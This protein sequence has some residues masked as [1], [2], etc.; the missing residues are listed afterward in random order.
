VKPEIDIYKQDN[1]LFVNV[2]IGDDTFGTSASDDVPV[3]M[4]VNLLMDRIAK[5]K[6]GITSHDISMAIADYLWAD[7]IAKDA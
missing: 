2:T 7:S 3:Q 5:N 6:L 1:Q 4:Y